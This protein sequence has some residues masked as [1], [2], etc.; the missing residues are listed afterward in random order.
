MT[1]QGI[2]QDA[3]THELLRRGDIGVFRLK[4]ADFAGLVSEIVGT[5]ST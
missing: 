2:V 3:A 4:G 1:W 5:R